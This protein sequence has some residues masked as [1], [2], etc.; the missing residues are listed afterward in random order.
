MRIFMLALMA[1]VL[2][3]RPDV[4]L[5]EVLDAEGAAQRLF[6]AEE[7]DPEW[8][9]N[10]GLSSAVPRVVQ[11]LHEDLG[12]F[13]AVEP[14]APKCLARFELGEFT[15]DIAVTADGLISSL[16]IDPPIIYSASLEEALTKFEEL[17]GDVS[18]HISGDGEVLGGLNSDS[19]LAVGSAFK[20]AVLKALDT[21]I[22]AG[23]LD[24]H[25]VVEFEERWRSLPTGQLQD[26]PT[27]APLTIHT[28]ASLMISVSD[29]TATD[30]LID[31]VSRGS[32]ETISPLNRP[33]LTTREFFQLK[34]RNASALR[35]TFEEGEF[36]KRM[37]I[38]SGLSGKPLPA[39]GDL[40]TDPLLQIEWFFSGKELCKLM[41][42]V[43]HLDVVQ[44][45]PGI[46]LKGDWEEVAYKGGSDFGA[47]NFT[48]ALI[49]KDGNRYCVSATWNHTQALDETAFSMLYAGLLHHL[50]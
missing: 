50:K 12:E 26:W 38:L 15:F 41:S 9:A 31:L 20:L 44:I 24:W 33:F 6:A 7:V 10:R 14:C 45:N 1:V 2:G 19:V 40:N 22:G 37:Q 28:L 5:A 16:W 39:I 49:S 17:P 21:L 43:Q 36:D 29:N 32:L 30:A 47:L 11:E 48:T 35:E 42:D 23:K 46:A 13:R 4:A 25:Q 27:G 18:V 34:R 8:F 3:G